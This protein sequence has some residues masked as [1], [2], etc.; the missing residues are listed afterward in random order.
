MKHLIHGITCLAVAGTLALDAGAQ[1]FDLIGNSGKHQQ[2]LGGGKEAVLFEHEG[3]GCLTH[4]WFGGNFNGVEDTRIR[5]YIDGEET[6]SIDMDLYMGHG[7][8]F[9][10]NRAPWSNKHMGKIGARNGFFN[11]FRIPFGTSVRVTAQRAENADDNQPIWWIIRGVENGRVTLG[12][13]KLPE[14]ARLKLIRQENIEVDELA[15]FDLFDAKGAGAVFKVTIAAEGLED[16]GITYL[17]GCIRAYKAGSKEPI[18]ISSGLEDYFL[19]TYYFDTGFFHSDTGGLTHLDQERKTF[20]AYRF[21]DEDPIFF[22][23]GLRMTCR[24]WE[25]IHG[26]PDEPPAYG[27]GQRTRYTTYSWVYQ[28]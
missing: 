16:G 13:E 22:S 28:W 2:I 23:K 24:N 21:H 3:K 10:D 25:S 5:Y 9:N 19:G 8:G 17:E 26:G 11:N 27:K 20:S 1:Q 7:I 6:A 18:L 14:T 15:E 4:F 12:G